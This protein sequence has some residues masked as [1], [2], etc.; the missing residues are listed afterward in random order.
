MAEEGGKDPFWKRFLRTGSV[1]SE[2]VERN[3]PVLEDEIVIEVLGQPGHTKQ[4]LYYLALAAANGV[5]P[6]YNTLFG[7][8]QIASPSYGMLMIEY[9]PADKWVR[10]RIR[11]R[12]GMAGAWVYQRLEERGS[13]IDRLAVY[14]GP[15]CQVVGG[16]FNFVNVVLPGVPARA[17]DEKAPKM[18]FE[19]QPILTTCPTTSPPNPSVITQ[20]P[21]PTYPVSNPGAEIPSPNPKPPGDNRSRGAVTVPGDSG[22]QPQGGTRCCD[23][24]LA[25]IPLVFAALSAPATNADM[26]WITPVLGPKGG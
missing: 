16:K 18:P 7:I 12:T 9:D 19:G 20:D 10:C 5:V 24:S 25:L 13:I 14:R 15:Q 1:V 11:Y 3:M 8:T 17:T 4:N 26:T 22:L 23:R 6:R 21:A 2:K